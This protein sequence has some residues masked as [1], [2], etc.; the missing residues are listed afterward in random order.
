M[1][2]NVNECEC[3]IGFVIR[4]WDLDQCKDTSNFLCD[5]EE[6]RVKLYSYTFC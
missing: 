4:D 6:I 2:C 3:W 1:M 5:S